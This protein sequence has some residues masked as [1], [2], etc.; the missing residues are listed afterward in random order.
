M[1]STFDKLIGRITDDQLR[2]ELRAAVADLRKVTDFGLVFEAHLPETVRLPHHPIR[3]GIKVAR[4]DSTD[5]SMF[6]V[7]SVGKT[8]STI[9]RVR[10]PDGTA[11]SPQEGGEVTKEKVP[12]ESLVAIAEFSDPIYPGL[13][14]V[15]AVHRGGDKPAHVVING[16]NFHALEALQFTHT[17]RV[18]CIYIDPPYNTRDR[19]WKYN[20]DYVDS[21]DVY[22]HSKWLAFM[23]RRLKLAK[24]L[25]N[26]ENSV[27]IVTIDEKEYSR[28]GMLLEQ[29][30]PGCKIQMV[31]I[32][33]NPKGTARYNEFSRVEE[34]AYFVFIG[35]VRLQS[36]NSDM[37]TARE[38]RTETH[39][40]WRGLARTGRKGLR[41]NNPGSWYPIFL[42][43]DD[44]SFHSIGEA[45]A[46]DVH[47]ST[48]RVPKGTIAVWPPTKDGDEYSWSTVPA[49]LRSIHAKGGL[50]IGRV[51]AA[52]RSFPFYYLSAPTF[53]K[54]ESGEIAVT[55]R[56][57]EG[58]LLIEF[59]VGSKSAAPRSVW[60]QVAHDAG[61]HGTGLVQRLIPGQKFPFPK[62][63]YAVEDAIRFFTKDKPNA[64]IL[65]FFAGSGTT[66]HAV[67][68][69]NRQ[70]GGRRTSI[71]VTNN[72]VSDQEAKEL[73]KQGRQPGDPK[74]E[75]L[76]I[77]EH[78]TRPRIT[79]AITGRTP[80]GKQ[81]KGDYKFND[82]FPM[83]DGFEENV[84][85]FELI[86]LDP[87]RVEV[88][89]AFAGI[90]PLLW[91]R[92]G[93][94]GPIIE[95]CVDAAGRHRSHAWTQQYGVLFD[96]DRWRSFV[97]QLPETATTAY[98]VT[99]SNTDFA[100]VA[101]ELPGHLDLVRLYERYLTT[102]A[103]N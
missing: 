97:S 86:Y 75:A 41:S 27:L 85:F 57:Q 90:A 82:P 43:S 34:Y 95:E 76:G 50:K 8:T 42:R 84:E 36:G 58:E 79:A 55:G 9:R 87:A 17:G 15:G 32:V 56:G 13:R 5:Q 23:D 67:A 25:L 31:S 11:L 100:H 91:L 83:A 51:N 92:A 96:T 54:I 70:D 94:S 3:R 52:K 18:D 65:D 33:I 16:E 69:L 24:Q 39:V 22:R 74:W 7:V 21:D 64:V 26:P 49:T 101:G 81:I 103:V 19:D 40:R 20:N 102:F 78:V 62:S 73:R 2:T 71:L 29:V 98:I 44:F 89:M 46:E 63:L 30:F 38:Y 72:E 77:F 12:S 1:G 14:H 66:A 99:D 28:L 61:S 48:V 68:R 4:R 37:L 80:S 10:R 47:E 88:D 59:A 93:A 53:E 45:I 6:Y 60:N 35:D